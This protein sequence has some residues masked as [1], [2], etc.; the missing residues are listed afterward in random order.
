M[1]ITAEEASAQFLTLLDR[2]TAGEPVTIT[3]QGKPFV[4]LVP[5]EAERER[6]NLTN[7]FKGLKHFARRMEWI[8]PHSRR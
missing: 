8:K 3:R 5:I 7:C 4:R 6:P 2:A 1:T